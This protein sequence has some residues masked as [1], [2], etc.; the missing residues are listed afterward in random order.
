MTAAAA[1]TMPAQAPA[2]DL[3]VLLYDAARRYL[4]RASTALRGGDRAAAQA[5]L[6]C[7]QLIFDELLATLDGPDDGDTSALAALYAHCSRQLIQAR[8]AGDAACVA[9]VSELAR[10]LA[11]RARAEPSFVQP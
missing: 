9:E 5:P 8:L 4:L 6:E 1:R 3:V 10:D 11:R 2:E 7:A